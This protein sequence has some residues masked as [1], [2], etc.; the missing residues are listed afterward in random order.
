MLKTSEGIPEYDNVDDMC[1]D[2][3]RKEYKKI[4]D[5]WLSLHYKTLVGLF[6]FA[7]MVEGVMGLILIHSDMLSTTVSRFFWKFF[8]VPSGLN[9]ICIVLETA[10]IKSKHFS[11]EQKIYAISL[12]FVAFCFVLFTAHNTFAAIYY[13]FII[14]IMLTMT[15]ASYGVTSITA[16]ASVVA[17]SC[18][19]LF[20]QWD[21][22]KISIYESTLQLGNFLIALFVTIAFSIVCMVVIYYERQKNEASIRMEIERR[23]MQRSLQ[24]DEMTGVFSRKAL[25]TAMEEME[26]DTTGDKYI[27]AIV[28]LDNF[29]GINDTWGHHLGD[30]CLIEFAGILKENCGKAIPFRYGGD[31]FCLLF[32]NETMEEAVFICQKIKSKLNVLRFEAQPILTLTVSF[33]LAEY[34]DQMDGV[35]LFIHAD[36]ALYEAKKTRDNVCV[37]QKQAKL[38]NWYYGIN[39]S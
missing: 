29:K 1:S 18:S 11:Q 24:V 39:L 23:Q 22:D 8:M 25:R 6:I 19:E 36:Y 33:G 4:D 37:F 30:Q 14:A 20:I 35:Q 26:V 3:I 15:Y 10:I 32:R 12:G 2:E 17:L 21:T 27:L 31:E 9:L 38:E 28:D 34:F 13:I 7:L 16:L 5:N